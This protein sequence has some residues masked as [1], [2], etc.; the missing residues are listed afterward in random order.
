MMQEQ[1]AQSSEAAIKSQAEIE[2]LREEIRQFKDN[3]PPAP[4]AQPQ[5]TPTSFEKQIE[6]MQ[7]QL[8]IKDR[9]IQYLQ[10]QN[11]KLIEIKDDNC[12][13][14]ELIRKQLDAMKS[15]NRVTAN[16]PQQQHSSRSSSERYGGDASIA[17]VMDFIKVHDSP[18]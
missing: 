14:I 2:S 10:E 15:S 13:Q 4:Q 6:D 5:S 9:F 17:F 7:T 16:G 12:A 1:S 11:R 8:K 3:N 18:E